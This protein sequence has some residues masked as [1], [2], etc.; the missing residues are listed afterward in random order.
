M[1]VRVES[2]QDVLDAIQRGFSQLEGF[3]TDAWLE[4]RP[5]S[6]QISSG[7][8]DEYQAFSDN[9]D[10]A[11]HEA[12]TALQIYEMGQAERIYDEFVQGAYSYDVSEDFP[13]LQVADFVATY[14]GYLMDR[15]D[16]GDGEFIG[17]D[18]VA[19]NL[20]SEVV[21]FVELVKRHV[22][23][24][25]TFDVEREWLS[26]LDWD[27]YPRAR[28]SRN[29]VERISDAYYNFHTQG[30]G[31]LEYIAGYGDAADPAEAVSD[32]SYVIDDIDNLLRDYRGD[33]EDAF[34][35]RAALNEVMDLWGVMDTDRA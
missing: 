22:A 15:E 29:E 6:G 32:F 8:R 2:V 20:E 27:P 3:D 5:N 21:T 14:I 4:A 12:R 1:P 33:V 18:E 19:K 28:P 23:D 34:P 30:M 11:M 16:Q 7:E 31:M 17:Q 35:T 24:L 26:Q 10:Y 9:V 25:S 13:P